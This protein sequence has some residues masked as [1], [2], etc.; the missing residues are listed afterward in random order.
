M[1]FTWFASAYDTDD[2]TYRL[3]TL[4]QIAG[5]LVFAVGVPAGL[6]ELDF[7]VMTL[8][9]VLM[10]IALIVQWLHAAREHPAGRSAT[11]RYAAGIGVVQVG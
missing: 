11:L 5:V 3:L 1:N 8:G 9:Y 10:R 2:V 7:T 4:L 6:G